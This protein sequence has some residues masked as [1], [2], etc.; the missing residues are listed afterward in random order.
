MLGMN[1]SLFKIYDEYQAILSLLKENNYVLEETT[2]IINFSITDGLDIDLL[3]KLASAVSIFDL[4]CNPFSDDYEDI[5]LDLEKGYITITDITSITINIEKDYKFEKIKSIDYIFFNKESAI[6]CIPAIQE[7]ELSNKINIGIINSDDIETELFNFINITESTRIIEPQLIKIADETIK[8]IE[9]YLSNNRNNNHTYY[10]NPYSFVLLNRYLEC[11]SDFS[12][13]VK[14]NFY[15][16]MLQSLSDKK[17]GNSYIIRGDKNISINS[18]ESFP[19]NNYK[20]FVDIFLFLISHQKYTEKFIITKKV[21]TLYINEKETIKDLDERL[22]EIWKTINYYYDHYIEDNLKDFFKTKDQLLKEAMNVS[23]VIYEQTDKIGNSIIGSIISTII[24]LITTLYR[25]LDGLNII[26]AS[27]FI[28]IFLLFSIGYY[29]L[30]SDS[31][32][33][34]YELTKAQFEHF[35]SEISII[36]KDE[37]D[38]IREKY[39][40]APYTE[41]NNSLRK[42]FILLIGVNIFLIVFFIFFYV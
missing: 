24:L 30:I 26:Y 4:N 14:T 27:S 22:P 6:S 18:L 9:F 31:T 3:K 23:K 40:N 16:E 20:N 15:Q 5:I 29:H 11:H 42:L 7:K 1:I 25:T 35:I 10:F 17:E 28:L 12:A 2:R 38:L 39:I 41:L 13:M 32:I 36:R 37:V 34:R 21:I 33:K 8:H 19:T